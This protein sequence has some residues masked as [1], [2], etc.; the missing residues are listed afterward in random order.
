[1]AE[2]EEHSYSS[3]V[4]ENSATSSA[5]H[6][7]QMSIE[8]FKQSIITDVLAALKEHLPLMLN[9]N[10]ISQDEIDGI[11]IH[12]ENSIVG[13]EEISLNENIPGDISSVKN[14]PGDGSPENKFPR[15]NP[16]DKISL[17][18]DNMSDLFPNRQVSHPNDHDLNVTEDIL[19]Q[20][21]SEMP[22]CVDLGDNVKDNLAKRVIIHHKQKSQQSHIKKEICNRHKLPTS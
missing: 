11:S 10:T 6:S 21:D 16:S 20:V 13:Y 22:Q 19:L 18:G 5:S 17:N 1:M 12:A 14:I 2:T 3:C 8:L 7:T 9:K 4:N 15:V